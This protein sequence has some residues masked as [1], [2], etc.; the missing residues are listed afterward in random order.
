MTHI[1]N[2]ITLYICQKFFIAS[3]VLSINTDIKNE[4]KA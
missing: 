4:L 3:I 1:S 2:C